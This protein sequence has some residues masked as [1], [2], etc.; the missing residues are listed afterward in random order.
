MTHR[1]EV[2]PLLEQ[3]QNVTPQPRHSEPEFMGVVLVGK[4]DT[5]TK[6]DS[7]WLVGLKFKNNPVAVSKCKL[8]FRWKPL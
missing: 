8:C 5:Y 3:M 2:L 6:K 4:E 7:W 1:L